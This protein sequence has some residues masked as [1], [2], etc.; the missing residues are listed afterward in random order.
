VT[1]GSI[2]LTRQ[3]NKGVGLE[4]SGLPIYEDLKLK[5]KE[6]GEGRLE[7]AIYIGVPLSSKLGG[8]GHALGSRR[9]AHD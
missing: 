8:S 2:R 1:A 9:L 3:S 5:R 6:E 4:L 7:A